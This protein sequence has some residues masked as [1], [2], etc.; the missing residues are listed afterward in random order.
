MV[1]R[2]L[3]SERLTGLFL[4]GLLLFTPPLIGAFDEADLVVGIPVLCLYLFVAWAA[5]IGMTALIVERPQDDDEF[6][7]GEQPLA[8][9]AD[10]DQ[11]V[12]SGD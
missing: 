10:L 2:G 7:E 5:L 9:N 3:T 4:F 8:A 11:T 1:R 12:G 6:T